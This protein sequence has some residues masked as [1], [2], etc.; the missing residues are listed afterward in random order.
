MA[1]AVEPQRPREMKIV[2]MTRF[3][4]AAQFQE[5]NGFDRKSPAYGGW[6]FDAPRAAGVPGHM[7]LAHTRRALEAL[8]AFG[9]WSPYDVPIFARRPMLDRATA[10]LAVVQKQADAPDGG[11][12]FSPV[13]ETANKAGK[14]EDA[15]ATWRELRHSDVRRRA[16]PARRWRSAR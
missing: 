4:A 8:A 2:E 14:T 12:Y 16:R 15:A 10:F 6:G 7:D 13:V 9:K 5:A 1:L 11:F 3:L